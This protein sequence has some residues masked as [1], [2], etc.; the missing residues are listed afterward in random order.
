MIRTQFTLLLLLSALLHAQTPLLGDER[1][2]SRATPVHLLKLYDET[3]ALILPGDQPLMPFSTRTTCGKC[4]DYEQIRQ[5]WHFNAHLPEVDPGRPGEPWIYVDERT[6]TQIPLSQR[7]WPGTYRPEQIGLSALAFLTRFGR[8]APGGGIGEE[9]EARPPEEFLRWMVSGSLEVNCLSCHDAEPAFDA[10]EYSRSVLRQN[11]RWAAAAGSGF[12]RVEGSARA[13]PDVY[14]IYA[15]FAPDLPGKI[16]PGVSYDPARFNPRGEVFFD[17]TRKIAADRCYYCHSTSAAAPG[18]WAADDDVHLQAGMRC[19][20]CH[21]NGLDHNMVRGYEGEM[22]AGTPAAALTCRGC[23]IPDPE[24]ARP[25]A[26]RLGA[27]VPEHP[28]IPAVHFEKMSCTSCHAGPWPEAQAQ[29]R[30]TSRAHALGAHGVNKSP[31]VP[32]AILAPVFVLQEDGQ[33]A[34]H[35]MIW[36][37]FWGWLRDDAV[38][39]L[40]EETLRLLPDSLFAEIAAPETPPPATADTAA[41][42]S[43]AVYDTTLTAS[44]ADSIAPGGD[45]LTDFSIAN[46]AAEPP[47]APA[48]QPISLE[49]IRRVLEALAR[50]DSTSVPVYISGGKLYRSSGNHVQAQDHPAAAP[51]SWAIGHDV[52]PAAQSLGVRGCTDCHALDAPLYF[53]EIPVIPTVAEQPAVFTMNDFQGNSAF[54]TR[55][56][57]A[58]FFF[59]PLLKVILLTTGILLAA[60]LLL[61]AFRGLNRV[62]KVLEAWWER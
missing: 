5:G 48:A 32:P 37:A 31:E 9:E 61:L 29:R 11:F 20:D 27:P 2:G 14:D 36:P 45:S 54:Y 41:I 40:R 46:T 3:G 52:R 42:D 38:E 19:V 50:H 23:H 6:F 58:S 39:P 17:L 1:D 30:K 12:A 34:P 26:G 60:V 22:P 15:G 51:Y 13:M 43:N 28:G 44:E 57:A 35:R 4:H 55:L 25:L 49:Q 33:I 59:R 10:A 62:M 24:A 53:G 16:P 8:H 47:A 18:P 7:A 21:R 56:F